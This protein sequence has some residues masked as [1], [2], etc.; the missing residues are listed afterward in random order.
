M[1]GQREKVEVGITKVSTED[2]VR[3][4]AVARQQRRRFARLKDARRWRAGVVLGPEEPTP[5]APAPADLTLGAYLE[6]YLTTREAKTSLAANTLKAYETGWRMRFGAL[7]DRPLRQLT[8]DDLEDCVVR[9]MTTGKRVGANTI[10]H[11]LSGLAKA[12]DRAKLGVNPARELERPTKVK[13]ERVGMA[14]AEVRLFLA[15][16][17]GHEHEALFL[18][19]L[20]GGLRISEALALDW[21]HLDLSS[22]SPSVKVEQTIVNTRSKPMRRVV[23]RFAKSHRGHREVLLGA[24]TAQALRAH[25]RSVL[26]LA[27]TSHTLIGPG[28]PVF[29]GPGYTGRF[30]CEGAEAALARVCGRLRM[31]YYTPHQLRHTC[32]TLMYLAKAGIKEIAERLGDSERTVLEVYIHTSAESREEALE[33]LSGML[34]G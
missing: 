5:V 34:Y 22:E 1:S 4:E 24:R 20:D 13:V 6:R 16:I 31:P 21:R 10:R 11:D 17:A 12:L 19:L 14:L 26:L 30:T 32:A 18:L 25:R 8:A 3:F 9:A 33:K 29:P 15:E 27:G 23:Q 28:T 2:G 7:Y